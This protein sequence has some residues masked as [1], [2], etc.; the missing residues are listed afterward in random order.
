LSRDINIQ[1]R[2]TPATKVPVFPQH[3][4]TFDFNL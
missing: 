4:F 3:A 2:V 1:Y